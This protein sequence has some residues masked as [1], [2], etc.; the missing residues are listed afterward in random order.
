MAGSVRDWMRSF[1]D[2][3]DILGVLFVVGNR[4]RVVG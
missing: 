1:V 4:D 2:G 3:V